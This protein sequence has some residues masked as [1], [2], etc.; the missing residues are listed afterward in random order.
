MATCAHCGGEIT[1]KFLKD[2]CMPCLERAMEALTPEHIGAAMRD[3]VE[4]SED[5]GLAA[6]THYLDAAGVLQM[7][8]TT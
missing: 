2:C 1:N 5:E 6:G 4:R 7:K 3:I 8:P